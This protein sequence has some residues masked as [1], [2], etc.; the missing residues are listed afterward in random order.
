MTTQ[1]TPQ[2][3][4]R[5]ALAREATAIRLAILSSA[6]AAAKLDERWHDWHAL[7]QARINLLTSTRV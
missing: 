1:T 5:S 2:A 4:T 3:D 7:Q 6:I